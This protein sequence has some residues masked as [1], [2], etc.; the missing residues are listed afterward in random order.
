MK[1]AILTKGRAI[2]PEGIEELSN[3]INDIENKVTE[4]EKTLKENEKIFNDKINEYNTHI[5]ILKN[6]NNLMRVEY[7]D[8][9]DHNNE[10]INSN[11]EL[12][13]KFLNS[14]ADIAYFNKKLNNQ[15]DLIKKFQKNA[16]QIALT[17]AM[18]EA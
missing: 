2:D 3:Y 4:L 7:K 9:Y 1:L 12:K 16:I 8:I 10:L 6:E 18:E 13:E 15:R 17:L 14:T 11:K 5:E